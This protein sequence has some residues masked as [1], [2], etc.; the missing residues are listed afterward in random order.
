MEQNK[1]QQQPFFQAENA[2]EQTTNASEE[3]KSSRE[4]PANTTRGKAAA[5]SIN[6]ALRPSE[7]IP[8][9]N[10]KMPE[11]FFALLKEWENQAMESHR[12]AKKTSWPRN[13]QIAFSKR[14]YLF[15]QIK[16]GTENGRKSLEQA[17]QHLDNQRGKEK[18]T[19]FYDRIRK[20]DSTIS[21]RKRKQPPENAAQ[22]KTQKN[23]T[24]QRNFPHFRRSTAQNGE[25]LWA[26]FHQAPGA[27]GS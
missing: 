27:F 20:L 4:E 23:N 15:D 6:D 7:R 21:R 13:L 5:I 3:K 2:L 26:T 22:Q 9:F 24:Q 11:S 18:L 16:K 12:H 25:H 10:T 17:A 14:R 1:N 19:Q 8:A